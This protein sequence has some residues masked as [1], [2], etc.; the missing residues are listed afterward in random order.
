MDK[1]IVYVGGDSFA[2]GWD[3][4]D[5]IIPWN[6]NYST[7]EFKDL[8]YSK[9]IAKVAANWRKNIE[10]FIYDNPELPWQRMTRKKYGLGIFI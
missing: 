3:L 10:K 4:V 2:E 1:K 6:V 9:Q 8:F 7:T 5:E